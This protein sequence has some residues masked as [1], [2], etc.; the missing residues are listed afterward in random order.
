MTPPRIT[1]LMA[2]TISA[3][4]LAGCGGPG[5]PLGPPSPKDILAK[6]LHSNLKDAH[7]VV[8]GKFTQ[9]GVSVDLA[10]DGQLVYT[11]PG[12]GRFKFAIADPD[13][14]M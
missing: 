7:F 13:T 5:A 9:Q 14:V 8:T 11:P 4:V 10:G 12:A 1:Q 6:P 3:A 2:V